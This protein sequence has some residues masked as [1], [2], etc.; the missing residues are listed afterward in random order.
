[1]LV[2]SKCKRI[3]VEISEGQQVVNS[4]RCSKRLLSYCHGHPLMRFYDCRHINN[5]IV[6]ELNVVPC[7]YAI[8][9]LV[10][11]C[12]NAK[13]HPFPFAQNLK[14]ATSQDGAS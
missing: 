6:T 14:G 2:G 9:G 12:E 4:L 7:A 13:R 3:E 8:I 10:I 11:V 5:V 1:M